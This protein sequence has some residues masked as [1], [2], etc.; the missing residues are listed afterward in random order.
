M[1]IEPRS[2]HTLRQLLDVAA[3]DVAASTHVR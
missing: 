2:G 1:G 3:D